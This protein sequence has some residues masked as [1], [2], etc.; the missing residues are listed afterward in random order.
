MEKIIDLPDR[1]RKLLDYY[2]ISVNELAVK[3]GGSRMKYYNLVNGKAKPD[4]DTTETILKN[5]PE[6]SAEWFMRGSGPMLKQDILSQDQA[7]A[8]IAENKAIKALYRAEVAGKHRDAAMSSPE[9][10]RI[11]RKD[12][13]KQAIRNVRRS[14]RK[15]ITKPLSGRVQGANVPSLLELFK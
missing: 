8:I 4:F 14:G 11:L 13:A 10:D 3:L 7:Q 15:E 1:I 5:F 2:K 6:I 12:A 9:R